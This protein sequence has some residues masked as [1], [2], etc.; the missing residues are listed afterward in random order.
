M[1]R[2]QLAAALGTSTATLGRMDRA[3]TGPAAFRYP[4]S[5]VV[6]YLRRDVDAWIAKTAN[7]PAKEG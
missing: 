7:Q 1:T 2:N 4:G 3:G 5:N 6:R